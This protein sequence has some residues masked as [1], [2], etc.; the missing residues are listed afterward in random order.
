MR[1]IK[2]LHI[3]FPDLRAGVAGELAAELPGNSSG[4]AAEA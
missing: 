2:Y 4:I 3:D 1:K